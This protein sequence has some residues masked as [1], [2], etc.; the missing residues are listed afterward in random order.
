MPK[1][2]QKLDDNDETKYIC[3]NCNK[4]YSKCTCFIEYIQDIIKKLD[5]EKEEEEEEELVEIKR[6]SKR[7]NK[8]NTKITFKFNKLDKNIEN[9]D[10]LIQLLNYPNIKDNQLDLVNALIELNNL[11]G[12]TILKQQIINQILFFIKD[13]NDKELY[14]NSVIIGSPGTGKTTFINILSK[15]YKSIGFLSK[16]KVVKADRSEL[17]GEYLGHTAIKT[18]KVLNSALGGILLIDEAYSLGSS[19]GNDS[20][21][22]ECI[23]TINQFLSEHVDDFVCIIA[24]YEHEIESCFFKQNPGLKRRFAWKFNI[25][26]YNADELYEIFISQLKDWKCN[27]D[28]SYIINSIKLNMELF[29]GNGGDTKNLI[30]RCRIHYARRNFQTSD[31]KTITKDDFDKSLN[32]LKQS[33]VVSQ[34]CSFCKNNLIET[35]EKNNCI[36]C[37]DCNHQFMYS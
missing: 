10:D 14:L 3:T 31:N 6:E 32:E 7:K 20:F 23:D 19:S 2:K 15:I 21:S 28:K 26:N 35:Q 9:L 8:K 11:I 27:L 13:L 4:D 17:I 16:N 18:K 1:K 5:E 12:M 33:K 25:Q 30:D 36:N 37:K 29:T 22:K 34:L 24:G